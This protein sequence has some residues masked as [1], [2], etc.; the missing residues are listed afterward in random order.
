[1]EP[2]EFPLDDDEAELLRDGAVSSN[3]VTTASAWAA[4]LVEVA[5]FGEGSELGSEYTAYLDWSS[6]SFAPSR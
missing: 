5:G 6:M 2:M 1:M 4:K 3:G